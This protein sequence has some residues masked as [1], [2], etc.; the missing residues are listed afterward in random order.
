MD[1]LPVE[2]YLLILKLLPVQ[3]LIQC[4][5]VNKQWYSTVNSFQSALQVNTLIVSD[6][7]HLNRKWFLTNELLDDWSNTIKIKEF[8][9]LQ[10]NFELNRILFINVKHLCLYSE[11]YFQHYNQDNLAKKKIK[12]KFSLSKLVNQMEQLERI[13]V[14]YLHSNLLNFT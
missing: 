1:K 4:K 11:Y 2:I 12:K 7:Y 9:S 13:E 14:S 8:Q 5:R 6:S 10:S 3:Q